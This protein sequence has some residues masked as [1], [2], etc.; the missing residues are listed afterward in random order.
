LIC[1]QLLELVCSRF[2]VAI[3]RGSKQVDS[4]MCICLEQEA[5]P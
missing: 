3:C 5:K 2:S 4:G 1:E